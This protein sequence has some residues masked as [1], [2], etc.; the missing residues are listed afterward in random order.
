MSGEAA[1]RSGAGLVTV[2]CPGSLLSTIAA[3]MPELM[4]APLAETETGGCAPPALKDPR[5]L[6][7]LETASVVAIGP[8]MGRDPDTGTFVR[9]LVDSVGVPVVLDADGL[10]AFQGHLDALAGGPQ[11]RV[12]TPHPGEMGGLIGVDSREV[13]ARRLDIAGEFATR[14]QIYVV[15]KGYRTLVATPSGRVFVNPT[16]NAGMASAGSGDV[17]TGMIAATLGQPHLGTFGERLCLAVYLHGLAGD[18]AAES[19]GE[20][21]LT[22]TGLLEFLSEAWAR[23]RGDDSP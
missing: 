2:A 8:G 16:G 22:A 10:Y 9:G 13:Q 17:L 7:L 11:P 15:L 21:A 6:E 12:I 14:H 3:H 1:L 4:T 18:I 20:E 5:L 19:E 23:L